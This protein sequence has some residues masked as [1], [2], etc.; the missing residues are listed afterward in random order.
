[1]E[2]NYIYLLTNAAVV[3][4][5]IM[6]VSS[7]INNKSRE[8]EVNSSSPS[9]SISNNYEDT[10]EFNKPS[11]NEDR[12]QLGDKNKL[13]LLRQFR[14]LDEPRWQDYLPK[15]WIGKIVIVRLK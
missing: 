2:W 7:Y 6:F 14:L 1:V 8:E 5:A 9:L 12:D 3:D 13:T 15:A 10:K 4:D 11:Y